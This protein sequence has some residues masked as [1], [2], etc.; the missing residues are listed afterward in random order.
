MGNDNEGIL[1]GIIGLC[2]RTIVNL[3]IVLCW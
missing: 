1:N 2:I 3:V